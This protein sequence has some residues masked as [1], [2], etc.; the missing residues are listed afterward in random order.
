[1]LIIQFINWPAKGNRIISMHPMFSGL[2]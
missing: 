1:M 2:D